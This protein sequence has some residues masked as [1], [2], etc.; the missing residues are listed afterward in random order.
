MTPRHCNS[1]TSETQ[2]FD[3]QSASGN[4]YLAEVTSGMTGIF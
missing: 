2:V 3:E 4:D 1:G